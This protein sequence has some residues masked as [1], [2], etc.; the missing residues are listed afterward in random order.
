MYVLTKINIEKAIEKA[1]IRIRNKKLIIQ[2]HRN[3]TSEKEFWKRLDEYYALIKA[4]EVL[5][6]S[7]KAWDTVHDIMQ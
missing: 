7:L 2:E 6:Q 1:E 3:Y 4:V 5:K